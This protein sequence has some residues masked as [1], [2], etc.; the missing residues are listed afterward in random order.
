MCGI[1]GIAEQQRL[2]PPVGPEALRRMTDAIRHRGPDEDG[3]FLEPGIALGM[4]RLSIIDLAA[5]HQPIFNEDGSIC[6]V[7]NGEIYNFGELR[8]R[9]ARSGHRLATSGDTETIVHLYEEHGLDFVHHLRGM[10][11]IALW[12]ARRER[13]VLARD[14]MGVKPL[15]FMH[16]DEGIAF[17][18]EVKSLIAGEILEPRLDP[19]GAELFMAFGYVPGP[20]TL[21]AGVQKLAPASLL[22]WERG[23]NRAEQ[24][25]YWTPWDAADI[26]EG[27][28][29]E[30]D[31]EQLLGLLRG[32]VR[33]QMVSDVPLGVMLSGGVDSSLITA[34]MAEQ[35]SAPVKTFAVGF[36][37]DAMSNELAD[38]RAVAERLGTD[39][40]E[41][42]TSAADQPDLL[43]EM[44]WHQEEPIADLSGLGML[45]LS[46]LASEQVKVALCGQ[47]ADELLGGYRKHQVAATIAG[48]RRVPGLA[49]LLS[50]LGNAMP[51]GSTSARGLRSVATA[52]PVARL[53]AMSRI[54]QPHER[55]ALLGD[56]LR[57]QEGEGAI[58]DAV[59]QH[60]N[61]DLESALAEVLHLDTKLALVDNMLLYF[62]KLS[63]AASLE[64]R[65]PF[66]DHDLVA[67]CYALPD[68]RRV[69]RGRRK[70]LLKRVSKGLVDEALI[71]KRKRG[72]FHAGLG[73]WTTFHRDALL[74][75]VLLD[76]RARAR[77]LFRPDAVSE[78]V[79]GAG[80]G[81]KKVDQRLFCMF[82]LE[83]WNRYYVDADGPGVRELRRASRRREEAPARFAPT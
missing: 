82:L 1:C 41:L 7:F 13:L 56:A 65:V 39:H 23:R 49:G 2:Q 73:A 63:M 78:L 29:W 10:F 19:L 25:T 27:N 72:F 79:A 6:A 51:A 44:L 83:L 77:G 75:E 32:S 59:R 74:S 69:R 76:S 38:A 57:Q 9:L 60:V 17:G 80:N 67:F 54:V 15:Y 66:L 58:A 16:T 53:L 81:G 22:V 20:R 40:Y 46:R 34:L 36:A 61:P 33:G 24:R 42:L 21:F 14:H 4:R 45:I 8:R 30:D 64:V 3:H 71:E 12:D 28:D 47:G 18:S 31:E 50:G 52:D 11:A 35:A 48:V 62:D 26:R 43:G 37:D 55:E 70:E 5:S 68:N